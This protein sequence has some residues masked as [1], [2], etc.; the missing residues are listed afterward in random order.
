MNRGQVARYLLKPWSNDALAE[1]LRTAIEF[2]HLQRCAQEMEQ[3]LLRTGPGQVATAAKTS[4]LHEINT[5][6]HAL[7]VTLEQSEPL[8]AALRQRIESTPDEALRAVVAELAEVQNDF[9]LAVEQ[10]RGVTDRYR[11][12]RTRSGI[13]RCDCGSVATSTARIVRREAERVAK[14]HIEIEHSCEVAMDAT[15]LAQIL[16]NLIMNSVLALEEAGTQGA[17][18]SVEVRRDGQ[19]AV[20]AVIDTGPGVSKELSERIFEPLFTTRAGGTGMGL[21]IARELAEQHG[22]TLRLLDG[23]RGQTCLELRLPAL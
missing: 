15:V 8:L 1:V 23:E 12:S 19:D 4:L 10:L 6:L 20:I 18:I 5:P 11:R 2:F 17:S 14:F 3:R 21:A 9:A 22:G 7:V 13:L 16:L